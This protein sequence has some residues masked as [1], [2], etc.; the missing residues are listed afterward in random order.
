MTGRLI[1]GRA[2]RA[3][4]LCLGAGL[5]VSGL[6]ACGG[7]E[8]KVNIAA[9][10]LTPTQVTTVTFT[11]K[12]KTATMT[13]D[14]GLWTPGS[15]ATV[16]AATMLTTTA[17]RFFPLNAYRIVANANNADPAY[18]LTTP[19]AVPDCGEVCSVTATDGKRTWKLTVGKPSFNKAG[20]YARVD[21][22]PKLYLITQT[23]VA[24]IISEAT[25]QDFQFPESEKYRQVDKA[26]ND[27]GNDKGDVSDYDP[28]LIQV[29]AADQMA[30]PPPGETPTS[31]LLNA[32]TST[33]QQAGAKEQK[34]VSTVSQPGTPGVGEQDQQP[35]TAGQDDKQGAKK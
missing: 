17:D 1:K 25:G 32:A 29:L 15:G 14:G 30:S 20:F 19:N 12:G 28:Y 7:G 8:S 21:G 13:Q 31:V 9:I 2:R 22:D 3:G 16:Q 26:L 27:V 33:K 4:A 10:D 5:A 6:S 23:T 18:G 35:A 34:K 24:D 11:A